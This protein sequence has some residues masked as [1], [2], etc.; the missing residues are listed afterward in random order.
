MLELHLQSTIHLTGNGDRFEVALRP[1]PE[2]L[3][4]LELFSGY[5]AARTRARLLRMEH[6]WKILDGVD[7]LTRRRAEEAE[8]ARIEAKQWGAASGKAA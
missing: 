4:S 1:C 7:A 6:G 5:I 8:A 3:P 2:D